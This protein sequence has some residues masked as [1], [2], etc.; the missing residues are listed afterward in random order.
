MMAEESFFSRSKKS[1]T[2]NQK[3]HYRY[4]EGVIRKKGWPY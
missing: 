1:S 2:E 4:G 3:H